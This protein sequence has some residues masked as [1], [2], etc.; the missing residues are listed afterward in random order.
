MS[1]SDSRPTRVR[2]LIL[3]LA[4][5]MSWLL[6][7]HRYAWGVM[8]KDVGEEFGLSKVETGWIDFSFNASYALCQI[9]GGLAGDLF[10]PA[11]VLPLI[12]LFWSGALALFVFGKGTYSFI[13]LRILFGIG[14]AGTYPNLGKVTRSWFPLS[15]RTSTQGLIASFS[16]RMGGACAP[17]IIGTFM[18]GMLHLGWRETLVILSL[19]GVAYAI[20]FRLFFRNTPLEHS[21]TNEAEQKLIEGDEQPTVITPIVTL[22][23][24]RAAR[25]SLAFLMTQIFLSAFADQLFV[26][27]VFQFL[28]ESKGLTK[29]EMGIYGSLPL[30]GGAFGGLVAGLLIDQYL[31]RTNNL[32]MSRSVIGFVGKLLSAILVMVSLQFDDGRHMMLVVMVG[33][34]F[35]DWSQPAV[36]ATITDVSGSA[37]GRIFGMVNMAGSFGAALAGPIIGGIIKYQGWNSVFVFIAV[38]YLGT[39]LCWLGIDS[40]KKVIIEQEQTNPSI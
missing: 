13:S 9:P 22:T 1:L 23:R 30:F 8:K 12:I 32:R 24:S 15:I 18:M 14:Q 38:L 36:W 31:R 5:G 16:G 25:L 26:N 33:K 4:C 37:A 20:V 28:E 17:I 29:K 3:G 19:F 40:T 2:W 11:V 21:W 7:L 10:G 6:Y 35:T 39:A 27:W 34:F